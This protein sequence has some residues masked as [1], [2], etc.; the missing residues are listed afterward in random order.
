[1]QRTDG[2]ACPQ[3]QE[4]DTSQ[5]HQPSI[6][7]NLKNTADNFYGGE[8][9]DNVANWRRLTF[10]KWILELVRGVLVEFQE[11]HSNIPHKREIVFNSTEN[12]LVKQEISSFIKKD[13]SRGR[14]SRGSDVEYFSAREE[15]WKSEGYFKSEIPE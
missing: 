11:N 9:S 8:I 15:R 12:E 10:D 4:I 5:V 3:I 2:S 6:I 14:T 1:M 13:Y 7:D